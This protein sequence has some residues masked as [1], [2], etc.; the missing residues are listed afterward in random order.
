MSCIPDTP[1]PTINEAE[2]KGREF[3]YVV[4][5]E[6]VFI[7]FLWGKMGKRKR[8]P[9]PACFGESREFEMNMLLIINQIFLF[10]V[11]HVQDMFPSNDGVYRGF[12]WGPFE[13]MG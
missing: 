6:L 4:R 7:H 13:S 10:S 11:K 3:R 1:K 8:I 12:S 9:L 2:C 5:N